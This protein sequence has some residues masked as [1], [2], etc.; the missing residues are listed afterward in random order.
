MLVGTIHVA[1]AR[2]E[3]HTVDD[4]TGRAGSS[5]GRP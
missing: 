3:E 5:A 4:L 2:V 1:T